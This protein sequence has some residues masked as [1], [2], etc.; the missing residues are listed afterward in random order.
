VR[1]GTDEVGSLIVLLL[2]RYLGPRKF[3]RA[4]QQGVDLCPVPSGVQPLENVS[5]AV[6]HRLR[7]RERLTQL[8]VNGA[9]RPQGQRRGQIPQQLIK[10]THD[11]EHL[12]HLG[13][14]PRVPAPVPAAEGDLGN[15][16][17]RTEA[18]V[19]G[20]AAEALT[21]QI[22]VNAAPEAGLQ[23]GTGVPGGLV[24]GEIGRS[25]ER[26]HHTA[27]PETASAVSPEHAVR[28]LGGKLRWVV[29]L[30]QGVA[31]GPERRC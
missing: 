28:V 30:A 26:G 10:L 24:D 1:S 31:S 5:R 6:C 3:A 18:V 21:S 12:V 27:Q 8:V 9:G 15:L 7:R 19:H 22:V 2:A 16:L 13:C 4:E 29:F 11:R 17:A 23:V 14:G 20:T 25:R